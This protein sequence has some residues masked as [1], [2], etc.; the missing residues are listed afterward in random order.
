MKESGLNAT[1]VFTAEH[2]FVKKMR[3]KFTKAKHNDVCMTQL[4]RTLNYAHKYK[5][6]HLINPSGHSYKKYLVDTDGHIKYFNTLK[7][8]TSFSAETVKNYIS[9]V[10]KTIDFVIS[11][12]LKVGDAESKNYVDSL[13]GAL[14]SLDQYRKINSREISATQVARKTRREEDFFLDP[15]KISSDLKLWTRLLREDE[16]AVLK[17]FDYLENI[18]RRDGTLTTIPL[19]LKKSSGKRFMKPESVAVKA[20]WVR[21]TQHL[22]TIVLLGNATRPGVASNMTLNEFERRKKFEN[23]ISISVAEHKTN[24]STAASVVIAGD[25][26]DMFIRYYNLRKKLRTD[27]DAN[28]SFFLNTQGHKIKSGNESLKPINAKLNAKGLPEVN[29]TKFRMAVTTLTS[30]NISQEL[31]SV[32]TSQR[33]YQHGQHKQAIER[34]G[35]LR[36]LIM[37]DINSVSDHDAEGE[38]LDPWLP[39]ESPNSVVF[40]KRALIVAYSAYV[41]NKTEF[42]HNAMNKVIKKYRFKI[43]DMDT[44][45]QRTLDFYK[46][47]KDGKRSEPLFPGENFYLCST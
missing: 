24:T 14:M 31:Q 15:K 12:T 39:G 23:Q 6:A 19:I 44:F 43:D 32:L 26:D 46:S 29:M 35:T 34:A 16:A 38:Q 20:C 8:N 13:R 22:S 40:N 25:D 27:D 17:D 4:S 9:T 5:N 41:K 37:E 42:R 36:S 33:F 28:D 1:G 3:E 11:D 47:Y 2:S 18:V 45:L 30:H 7:E 10:M 21:V